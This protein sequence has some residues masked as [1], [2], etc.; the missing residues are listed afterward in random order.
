MGSLKVNLEDEILKKFREEAMKKF[1]YMKGSLSMAAREA[2]SN[3]LKTSEKKSEKEVEEFKEVLKKAAGIWT[4]EEGYKYI[5][6]IRKE[7]EKRA[8]RLKI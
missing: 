6:R 5:R 8:K 4:G 3:W 1:G 7:W 2:V